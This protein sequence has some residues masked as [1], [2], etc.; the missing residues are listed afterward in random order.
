[1]FFK[2][3]GEFDRITLKD[4]YYSITARGAKHTVTLPHML[5]PKMSYFIGFFLGDGGLKN[6][7]TTRIRSGKSEYKLIFGDYSRKFTQAL[8]KLFSGLFGFSPKI[9]NERTRK[10]EHYYYYNPT[11]KAVHLFLT[12]VIGF[13]EGSY[14]KYVPEIILKSSSE[15]QKWFLRG[16][17]DAEGSIYRKYK[18][19][20]LIISVHARE[21]GLL[22]QIQTVLQTS[23][24]LASSRLYKEKKA[25][26][27]FITVQSEV[28]N[29]L[30]QGLFTHPDKLG[31]YAAVAQPDSVKLALREGFGERSKLLF[32]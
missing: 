8:G 14:E 31:K 12:K 1:M 28:F 30:S 24:G 17:F 11:S 18:R 22:K 7:K 6:T 15:S 20:M 3:L 4:N 21:Y 16:Y 29:L 10:G 27:L 9:R 32:H 5:S 25:A 2:S 23:F 26:K 13:K 19:K